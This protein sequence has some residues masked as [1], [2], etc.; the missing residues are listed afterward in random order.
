MQ[1]AR[2]KQG[3]QLVL[4]FYNSVIIGRDDDVLAKVIAIKV[5]V[6]VFGFF[7]KIEVR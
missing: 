2:W 3:D 1:G 7:L 5:E 6:I 4:I